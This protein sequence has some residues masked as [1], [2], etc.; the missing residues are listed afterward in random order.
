MPQLATRPTLAEL[1]Q[2]QF[3]ARLYLAMPFWCAWLWLWLIKETGLTLSVN[4]AILIAVSCAALNWISSRWMDT[5][6][7]QVEWFYPQN[8]IR[9]SPSW[10]D[11]AL[12]AGIW[13][14]HFYAPLRLAAW[15]GA[16]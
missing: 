13:L 4:Q 5:A 11:R 3:H 10:T 2:D 6:D 8:L 12:L 7:Q 15:L 14:L 1:R 9:V 16:S